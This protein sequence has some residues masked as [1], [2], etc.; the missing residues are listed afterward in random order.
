MFLPLIGFT[1]WGSDTPFGRWNFPA[2]S[3]RFSLDRKAY[4]VSGA[5]QLAK[6]KKRHLDCF[7][8]CGVQM[9]FI[10]IVTELPP[11]GSCL[12]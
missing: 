11:T 5:P 12:L 4:T 2:E 1:I 10:F 8:G 7:L 9:A 6:G 3:Y